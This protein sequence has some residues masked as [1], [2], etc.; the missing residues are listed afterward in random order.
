M[1]TNEMTDVA[2]VL[3]GII[4]DDDVPVLKE[5]G[6]AAIFGPGTS[7]TEIAEIIRG[8]TAERRAS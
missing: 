2:L 5:M 7:T 8:I 1:T 4:P 3:G 6:V